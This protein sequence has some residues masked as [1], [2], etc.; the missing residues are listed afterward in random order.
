VDREIVGA[1]CLIAAAYIGCVASILGIVY[2]VVEIL[3]R[4]G[5]I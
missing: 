2:G 5:V 3:Q 4:A 1:G